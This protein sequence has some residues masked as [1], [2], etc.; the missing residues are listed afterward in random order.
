MTSSVA[1]KVEMTCSGCSG[2]VTRILS[3]IEGV[4]NVECDLNVQKV[5]VSGEGLD[6]EKM[7]AAL[8][9]WG[10]AA[11]KTVEVWK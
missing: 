1:Y 10:T 11:K 2:A 5:V 6:S 7:L 8:Q 4:A 9:K 3:K